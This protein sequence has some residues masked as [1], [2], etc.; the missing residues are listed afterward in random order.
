MFC[1]LATVVNCCKTEDVVDVF[2]VIRDLRVQKPGAVPTIVRIINIFTL[3]TYIINVSSPL[4]IASQFE[5]MCSL[6]YFHYYVLSCKNVLSHWLY[7]V[8]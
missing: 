2:Q 8:H 3:L 5:Y 4:I 6:H 1:T 7:S